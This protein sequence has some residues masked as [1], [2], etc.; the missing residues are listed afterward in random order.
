MAQ[1]QIAPTTQVIRT[2]IKTESMAIPCFD[3]AMALGRQCPRHL[4]YLAVRQANSTTA[5]PAAATMTDISKPPPGASN[6]AM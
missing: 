4:C 3:A 5:A 6:K 2:P 1:K